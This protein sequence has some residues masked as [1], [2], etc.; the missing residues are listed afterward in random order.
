[1]ELFSSLFRYITCLLLNDNTSKQ[2]FIYLEKW[3]LKNFIHQKVF[4]RYRY[5]DIFSKRIDIFKIIKR[6]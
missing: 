1:M 3:K 5:P 2:P 6:G 4:I